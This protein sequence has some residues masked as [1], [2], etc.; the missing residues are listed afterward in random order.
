VCSSDLTTLFGAVPA[1]VVLNTNKPDAGVIEVPALFFIV[2]LSFVPVNVTRGGKK[3]CVEELTSNFADALGV[4]VPIPVCAL[5]KFVE[6]K[7][8]NMKIIFF[9]N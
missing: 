6:S 8:D 1:A 7:I 4:V 5:A 9:I 2:V 3:P